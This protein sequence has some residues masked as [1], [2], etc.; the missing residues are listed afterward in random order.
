MSDNSPKATPWAKY[1]DARIAH[2]REL[3]QLAAAY[4]DAPRCAKCQ[5]VIS[6]RPD[7]ACCI[8][9]CPLAPSTMDRSAR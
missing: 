3:Q 7:E 5:I 2:A 6:L 1:R 9:D 8:A 4:R